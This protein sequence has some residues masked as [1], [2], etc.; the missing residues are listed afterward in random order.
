MILRTLQIRGLVAMSAEER[1]GQPLYD[2]TADCLSFLG[3]TSREA[4][5]HFAEWSVSSE[6]TT[7][8]STL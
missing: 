3:V 4:L 8:S 5:P 6:L 7:L 1:L 2:I